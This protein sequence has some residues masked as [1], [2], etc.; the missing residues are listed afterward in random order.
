[1]GV[2]VIRTQ[3]TR[4][5]VNDIA[6]YLNRKDQKISTSS[7]CILGNYLATRASVPDPAGP[8]RKT[9]RLSMQAQPRLAF[10]FA[11]A[12]KSGALLVLCNDSDGLY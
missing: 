7:Y 3:Y 1:M 9:G 12:R 4:L 5:S 2:D 10:K 8:H 6:S 11:Y